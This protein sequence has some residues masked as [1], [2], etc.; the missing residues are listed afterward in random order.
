MV[1]PLER[2]CFDSRHFERRWAMPNSPEG[3]QTTDDREKVREPNVSI[4]ADPQVPANSC[5]GELGSQGELN[6]F[7]RVGV[8]LAGALGLAAYAYTIS[9]RS[10]DQIWEFTYDVGRV[11]FACLI[12]VLLVLALQKLSTT[13]RI[14]L[15]LGGPI[16]AA[17]LSLFFAFQAYVYVVVFGDLGRWALQVRLGS[18]LS[19]SGV[20]AAIVAMLGVVVISGLLFWFRLRRRSFYGVTEA[21]IGLMM[22]AV[23]V[24]E[25]HD[26]LGPGFLLA[27]LTA[28]VYL[29]VR[30]LDNVH[31]GMVK[32]PKD[33][34]FLSLAER[35]VASWRAAIV[36]SQPTTDSQVQRTG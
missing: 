20:F 15:M 9:A 28:S 11:M 2:S 26:S 21:L 13:A 16:A 19:W 6:S 1:Q 3:A 5:E 33:E 36:E 23:K 31:Q 32:D 35:V 10:R 27:I 34:K 14:G 17:F 8:V 18:S 29:I 30:G 22:S 12:V 7:Q 25:P 24:N 4:P